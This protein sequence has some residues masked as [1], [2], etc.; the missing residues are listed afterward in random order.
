VRLALET[1]TLEQRRWESYR[2]MERE[3][4]GLHRRQNEAEQRRQGR[5]FGKLAK[6]VAMAKDHR[7]SQH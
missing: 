1:G 5:E 4:A 3:L 2:K 6:A 7:G